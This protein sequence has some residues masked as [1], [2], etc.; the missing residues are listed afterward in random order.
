V[1]VSVVLTILLCV[2]ASPAIAHGV[3]EGA[4]PPPN[5]SLQSSPDEVLLSFSE[6]ADPAFTSAVVVDRDGRVVSDPSRLSADGRRLTAA[7]QPLAV[8]VYTVRW[9]VLSAVD[10]HTTAGFYAFAVGAAAPAGAATADVTPPPLQVVFR[11]ISYVAA[12]LL[13]GTAFYAY[14][15]VRPALAAAEPHLAVSVNEAATLAVRRMVA[16]AAV[17]LIASLILGFLVQAQALFDAP[18]DALLTNARLR[19]ML[20]GTKL[21]WSIL[22]QAT[23]AVVLVIPPTRRGRVFRMA[24]VLWAAVVG[25]LAIVASTPG[26]VT[27]AQH[28]L[29]LAALLLVGTVYGLISVMAA[30]ILPLV[31]D[32][33]LPQALWAAPAAGALL[34]VGV[35]LNAHAG[36]AGWLAQ[37]ADWLHLAAASVWVGGLVGL[38]ATLRIAPPDLRAGAAGTLLPRFSTFAGVALLALVV[39][40]TYAAWLNVPAWSGLTLTPYGRT[41]LIKLV[42]VVPWIVLGAFNYFVMRPRLLRGADRPL[43][44]RFTRLVGGEVALAG[45]VLLAAAVLSITPPAKATMPVPADS[46]MV[47]AGIANGLRVRLAVRPSRVG[48][49]SY[50][51]TVDRG[52]SAVSVDGRVQLRFLKLDD[53]APPTLTVLSP[54]AAGVYR[55]EGPHLGLPGWWRV[56]VVLRQRGRTDQSVEF[57]LLL[58]GAVEAAATPEAAQVLAGA[59]RRARTVASWRE[60]DQITDGRGGVVRTRLAFAAPNRVHYQTSS[61]TEA[62]IIG[63]TRYMREGGPWRTD[64]LGSPITLDGPYVEY[65][66][67]PQ[68]AAAGRQDVCGSEPCRVVFWQAP[69][70]TARFA[71]WIGERSLLM[72]RLLM[73]A[74]QHYMTA[75]AFDFDAP[76]E[77]VPPP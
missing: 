70:G 29:H 73:V 75:T 38:L 23:M 8:G 16:P 25:T 44:R 9:R 7:L 48:W 26:G 15:T 49:N 33:R 3:L 35:T 61:G 72:Y 2:V 32:L 63:A 1:R 40:G 13:A 54:A 57:P 42:L 10:G 66:R 55:G 50:E 58:E 24:A 41:L 6:A 31:P 22:L 11:W 37:G 34:L 53:D 77:I 30:I 18:L 4:S 65:L 45:A 20:F 5:A 56:D 51:V 14:F 76:V 69:G 62:V 19:P 27:A 52:G 43:L 12:L 59:L 64:T 60:I 46:E 67:D 68:Q 28:S 21:G 17:I 47:L 36:G 71:G 39:T 74:P